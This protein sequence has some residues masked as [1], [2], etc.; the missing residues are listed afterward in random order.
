MK[1]K[2]LSFFSLFIVMTSFSQERNKSIL[3]PYKLGFLYNFSSNEN[4]IFDDVDYT[5]ITN[6]YKAQVF[7]KLGKWK[8]INLELI[9]QPQVQFLKHQLINEQF[10][11]PDQE[12]YLEKR[13]EFTKA[14][15]MNLYGLEFG[16][17]A[18][19]EIT[20]KLNLQGTISLGLSFIDTRTERLTK[21][22]TFIENF[23]LGFSYKIVK[24]S[25]IYIGT[26]FGHVSNLN[27][28]KPNDGYNVLGIEIG[29][30]YVLE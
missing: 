21:G 13:T 20:E 5:Y 8:N 17:G 23:S 25:Y 9:V 28:Q 12:N 18:K 30:S 6:T 3:K 14:K 29:Y 24:N 2:F 10:I 4:F 11:T 15:M 19:K 26:N 22:F 7:Y 27:F 1:N 16:F